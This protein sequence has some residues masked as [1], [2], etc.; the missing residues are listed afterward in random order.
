MKNILHIL[1]KGIKT[2]LLGFLRCIL[3]YL[4][5]AV[6]FS[7]IPCNTSFRR[8]E[9][10][11][12]IY[13]RTNGIHTDI[14]LPAKTGYKDWTLEL[15]AS[16]TV[17]GDTLIKYIAFG[18][19]SKSFYLETPQ[20]SDLRFKIVFKALFGMDET[21]MHTTNLR[22]LQEGDNC[23]KIIVSDTLFQKLTDYVSQTFEKSETG[24]VFC[25]NGHHY[26]RYDSFY[27]ANG[28]YSLF[29][30]CNSWVNEGLKQS[31]IKSCIWTPFDKGIFL[32]L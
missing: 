16:N 15:P 32:H 9:K 26:G 27:E 7:T 24:A 18:W 21:V 1:I 4:I 19:G 31:G 3:T 28:S 30:T 13:L 6:I 12:E 20:W 10:G 29:N 11:I 2:G 14:V 25:L 22:S 23:K 8:A 17:S 5:I